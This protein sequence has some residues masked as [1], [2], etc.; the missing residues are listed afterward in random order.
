MLSLLELSSARN[1]LKIH[2]QGSESSSQVAC[3]DPFS[4]PRYGLL[5]GKV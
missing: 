2:S 5:A 3:I 4:E 1:E